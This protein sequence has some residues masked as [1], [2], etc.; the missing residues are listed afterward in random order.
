MPRDQL[1]KSDLASGALRLF[2]PLLR[3]AALDDQNFRQQVGLATDAVIRLDKAGA[4]F[5]R[6]SLF[7]TIR[8][9]YQDPKQ[10]L[11]V[12]D[13]SGLTWRLA[14]SETGESV[15]VKRDDTRFGLP[16]FV[17]M[18]PNQN[19]RIEWFD[20]EAARFELNDEYSSRWRQILIARPVEDEEV[21]ELF[22]EIR[23]TP[24][25]VAD[26][27][28]AHLRGEELSLLTLVPS[29][30]RYY[31]RLVGAPSPNAD[32][33]SYIEICARPRFK[34]WTAAKFEGLKRSLLFSSHSLFSN[35]IPLNE[36]S[37]KDVATLFAQLE[38]RGDRVS[39]VGA[40]ETGLL[41]LD[42]FPELEP[43]IVK[44]AELIAAD[45]PQDTEGRMTLLSSLIVLVDGEMART[46]V[47]RD[48]PV[49][50]RRLAAI[51]QASVIERAMVAVGVPPSFIQQWAF[52][53]RGALYYLRAFIDLR[54]EP[55]WLPDFVL[56]NQ[57]KAELIGRV[58][59]AGFNS[60]AKLQSVGARALFASDDNAPIKAQIKFP[61]AFLPGP[62]EGGVESILE[63]PSDIESSLRRALESEEPSSEDFISLVN[64]PL[65]FKIGPQ[66]AQLAAQ[67][68]RRAKYELRNMRSQDEAFALLSG[69]A[70]VAAVTRSA[71]LAD[72]VRILVRVFRRKPGADIAPDS[73]MRI[74]LI[75]AASNA[76]KPKWCT[77]VGDWLTELSFEDMSR[78]TATN[79]HEHIRLLCKLEPDLWETCGRAEAA[80]AAYVDSSAN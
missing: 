71:E 33:Q 48:R 77:F 32:L 31:D 41:H 5:Q 18:S 46:G 47:G 58:Y 23:L 50:W 44:I 66:L 38:E 26:S 60:V 12:R 4:D 37:K 55:R 14:L 69:L 34:A 27:I 8:K 13:K 68:L 78:E 40:V 19:E 45:D 74:A 11:E 67:A 3:G 39:Q 21:D 62:L 10:D 15:L 61:F 20:R 73:A 52:P 7:S 24:L 16:N 80:L 29:E 35:A 54:R 65:I 9:L 49:F 25:F 53:A 17:C 30:V 72:E 57:L 70:T 1:T 51:A 76:D 79:L 64:S 28:A 36:Y 63:M 6:S 75:C 42:E 59:S 56:Q 22:S 2:P 43:H